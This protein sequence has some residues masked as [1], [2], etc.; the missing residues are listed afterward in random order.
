MKYNFHIQAKPGGLFWKIG[1]VE[2]YQEIMALA[3]SFYLKNP[4]RDNG[5]KCAYSMGDN[6]ELREID[7]PILHRKEK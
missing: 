3:N 4:N 6:A 5:A 1:F 7:N 2:T